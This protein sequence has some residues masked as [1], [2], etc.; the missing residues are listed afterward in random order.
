M[1]YLHDK[2]I[3]IM[4][5]QREDDPHHDLSMTGEST[6][7]NFNGSNPH[8]EIL[9]CAVVPAVLRAGEET[10][11]MI[12][13]IGDWFLYKVNNRSAS[14]DVFRWCFRSAPPNWEAVRTRKIF[15]M[16]RVELLTAGHVTNHYTQAL[17]VRRKT[18]R[19]GVIDRGRG[20]M[21]ATVDK[22]ATRATILDTWKKQ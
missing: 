3:Y 19:S 6:S 12:E 8:H 1:K 22:K 11:E 18:Q 10:A 2:L 16:S 13:I 20:M 7:W 5:L 14:T 9:S 21:L 15:S 17:S 4:K